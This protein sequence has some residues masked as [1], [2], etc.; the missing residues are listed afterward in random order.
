MKV[1]VIG[2]SRGL[3]REFVVQYLADRAQVTA[4]ARKAEDVV[5]LEALGAT[6]FPRMGS[7]GSRSTSAVW[8]YRA[9]KAALCAARSPR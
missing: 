2:A 8:L 7:I 1:L 3:G 4:T 5:E 6:A 9:S